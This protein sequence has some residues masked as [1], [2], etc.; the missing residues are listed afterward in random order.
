MR[1]GGVD[2]ISACAGAVG[3]PTEVTLFLKDN[4]KGCA[5]A[6][7]VAFSLAFF[8]GRVIFGGYQS[9]AEEVIR[10]S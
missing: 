2:P 5:A 1:K 6:V 8:Q 10:R 4:K 9:E 7:L 3:F